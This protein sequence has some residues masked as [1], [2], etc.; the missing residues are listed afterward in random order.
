MK[1]SIRLQRIPYSLKVVIPIVIVTKIVVFSLGFAA[2][3][4]NNGSASPLSILMNQFSHWDSI[5][6]IDIAK[7]GYV[8]QGYQQDFIVYFPLYPALIRL[9][10]FNVDYINL[11]ALL[12]SNV[13]SV[14]AAVFLFK[15]ARF[16]FEDNI[17]KKAVLYFCVFPTAYFLS[18]IYTEGLFLALTI[19]SF[20]YARV[21]KWPAAGFLSMFAALTRLGGLLLLPALLTEYCH[22]KR[23]KLRNLDAK[24]LWVFLALAG[25]L[26]FL[27]INVQVAG[28]P[29]AFMEVYRTNWNLNVNPLAGFERAL[30]WSIAAPFPENMYT[31]AELVFAGFGLSMVI[32]G[33]LLRFRLSYNIYMLLTWMLS[34]SMSWWM[35]VPRYVLAMFPVFILMGALAQKK[36]IHYTFTLSFFALLCFFTV[37]F[38]LNQFVF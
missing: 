8:Y 11:S 3:A 30:E 16:D 10:T 36:P 37:L 26:I 35:S 27:L 4:F 6:Y 12:V 20:Y 1:L 5:H 29:F 21:G 24:V 7:N 25:F 31:I 13:S 23:W 32:A 2:T 38:S 17:A 9:F 18:A 15:L 33:F 34:V 14:V 28:K 19:A 22:Q